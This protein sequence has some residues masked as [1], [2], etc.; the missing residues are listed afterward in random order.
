MVIRRVMLTFTENLLKEPIIYSL[1]QQFKIS[2]NIQRAD[3]SE[4]RGWVTLDL[5]GE[6]TDINEAITWITSRGIRTELIDDQD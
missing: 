5:K 3:I 4:D 6:E 2:T 1:S